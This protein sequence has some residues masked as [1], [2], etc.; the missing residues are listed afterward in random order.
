[1]LFRGTIAAVIAAA[2]LGMSAAGEDV[3]GLG[4][5]TGGG[6]VHIRGWLELARIE[7]VDLLLRAK[8]DSGALT[9][10]LHAEVLRG[11]AR[12]GFPE[13]LPEDVA[14]DVPAASEDD[15]SETVVFAVESRRGHRVVFEREIVRW[16]RVK[17]RDGG[18]HMRPVV[19]MEFCIG[20]VP[21]EGDVGLT[22]RSEFNY[23]L[24]VGRR[25]LTKSKIQVAA[26]ETFTHESRCYSDGPRRNVD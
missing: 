18:S 11:P 17:D 1:M 24:L 7:P 6:D 2:A 16:V 15:D 10:A 9:S 25:M 4:A 3:L 5:E 20:G 26:W 22:D 13:E 21:V 12:R 23:P 19:H 8:L 14:I